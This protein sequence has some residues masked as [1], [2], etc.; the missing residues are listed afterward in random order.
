MGCYRPEDPA[1]NFCYKINSMEIFRTI[2]KLSYN[3]FLK[4]EKY[5]DDKEYQKEVSD[6][7]SALL[8]IEDGDDEEEI[9]KTLCNS[10]G[11]SG[12]F[13]NIVPFQIDKTEE[14]GIFITPCY[15]KDPSHKWCKGYRNISEELRFGDDIQS[16][17]EKHN[18]DFNNPDT[19]IYL[20]DFLRFLDEAE[21]N[22]IKDNFSWK[23][24]HSDWE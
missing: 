10:E 16:I 3:W 19:L 13:Y 4:S 12:Y 2:V 21:L 5:K 17:I 22:E 14:G 9:Y 24:I 20:K 18:I 8:T 1:M 6:D 23:F 7:Y 15:D 11:F